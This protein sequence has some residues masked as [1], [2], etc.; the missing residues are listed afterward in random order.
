MHHAT[1]DRRLARL[2]L[3]SEKGAEVTYLW[4]LDCA[5]GGAFSQT[6][7]KVR[8]FERTLDSLISYHL[9]LEN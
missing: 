5:V 3:G 7:L 9:A 1:R 2:G 6:R 4:R 8:S